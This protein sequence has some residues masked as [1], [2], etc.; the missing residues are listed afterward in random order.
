MSMMGEAELTRQQ[1]LCEVWRGDV[2]SCALKQAFAP[3]A[4]VCSRSGGWGRNDKA[5]DGIKQT[6]VNHCSLAT[7]ELIWFVQ[8]GCR[9][10]LRPQS[11]TPIAVF[12]NRKSKRRLYSRSISV[13]D[14]D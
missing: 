1:R 10:R 6:R 9:S 7:S 11:M 5:E 13:A 3:T 12:A 2:V 8:S 14:P 4:V